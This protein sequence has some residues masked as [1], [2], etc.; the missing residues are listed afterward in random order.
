M[1]SIDCFI[2]KPFKERYDN[3]V[4]IDGKELITNASIEDY[5]S[6]SK[7]AVVVSTPLSFKS[8]IKKG[9]VVI[10]HHNIFRRFY[11][12]RGKEKNGSLY[13]KP[14]YFKTKFHS[15]CKGAFNI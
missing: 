6:I 3:K 8:D 1:K 7:K 4:T 11:D 14:I 13:F 10:I 5:K 9:D 15:R 12:I 2:V